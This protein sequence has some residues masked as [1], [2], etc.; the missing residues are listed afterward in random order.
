[1]FPDALSLLS[2]GGFGITG[3]PSAGWT[4]T[5][6]AQ[7]STAEVIATFGLSEDSGAALVIENSTPTDT[8][9]APGITGKA[10]SANRSAL[11]LTAQHAADSGVVAAMTFRSRIGAS[12]LVV[13]RPLFDW[14]N[15][16]TSVLQMLALNSGANSALSWGT[17]TGAVPAFTTRSAGTRIIAQSSI[18]G[19]AVDYAIGYENSHL[20]FSCEGAIS[21]RGFKWYAGTTNIATLR[22]DGQLTTT[23]SKVDKLRVALTTPVTVVAG[24]D[25]IV[26]SNLTTPGAVAVNLPATPA[27]GLTY[28][29]KDGKG[30]AGA[31]NITITPAAGNIDGV[32]TLVIAANYGRAVLTYNGTE[33]NVIT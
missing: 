5:K 24:T 31:N 20:W 19:S 17:Q 29:I 16:T 9:F 4:F 1:M 12:T 10:N 23:G 26:V 33:W 7:A 30:D 2:P 15:N 8:V 32:G 28:I 14:Q 6:T 22:G 18:S 27:T 13:T 11:T 21:A 3:S 25:Y